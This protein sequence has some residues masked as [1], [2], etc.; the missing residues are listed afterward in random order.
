MET[1]L[2]R[3]Q[4]EL[5]TA[6]MHLTRSPVSTRLLTGLWNAGCRTGKSVLELHQSTAAAIPGLGKVTL[7][8]LEQLKYMI[9]RSINVDYPA[10]LIRGAEDITYL[11]DNLTVMMGDILMG[12]SSTQFA[13]VSE[14]DY[15]DRQVEE[16]LKRIDLF[17]FFLSM[18]STADFVNSIP[19]AS[20][21]RK[22]PTRE[23]AILIIQNNTGLSHE[24]AGK[25]VDAYAGYMELR[26]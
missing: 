5:R 2:A 7:K 10:M 25:M 26:G 21:W 14:R 17:T 16:L 8:E 1:R 23:S 22:A 18:V 3:N 12:F 11:T 13:S 9:D 6:I 4:S 24:V 19:D 20:S 15:F